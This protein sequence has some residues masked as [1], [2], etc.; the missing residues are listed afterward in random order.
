VA[1]VSYLKRY[2]D[3]LVRQVNAWYMTALF[4]VVAK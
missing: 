2:E 4:A 3:R 1:R